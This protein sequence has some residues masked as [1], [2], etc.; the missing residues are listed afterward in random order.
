[1]NR[2]RRVNVVNSRL[3]VY[4]LTYGDGLGEVVTGLFSR[5]APKLLPLGKELASK[6]IGTLG[7][8]VI[9]EGSTRLI[10]AAKNKLAEIIRERPAK[11]VV[12]PSTADIPAG[13]VRQINKIVNQ[14]IREIT[15]S[16]LKLV[17]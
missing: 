15:G 17:A 1:M 12:L 3:P 8:T 11:P 9:D 14:R 5:V 6:A 13:T 4:K 7:K 10:N 2:P 16:G